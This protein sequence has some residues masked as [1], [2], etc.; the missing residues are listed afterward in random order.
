MFKN[1]LLGRKSS[2]QISVLASSKLSGKTFKSVVNPVSL[3]V[4][5]TTDLDV[6]PDNFDDAKTLI[7]NGVQG[8]HAIQAKICQRG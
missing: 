1:F 5:L 4:L 7:W 8:Q 6:L 2:F 3:A